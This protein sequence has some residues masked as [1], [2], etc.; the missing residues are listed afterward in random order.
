MKGEPRRLWLCCISRSNPPRGCV[1]WTWQLEG[2]GGQLVLFFRGC[3]FACL[4]G[5][6]RERSEP[7]LPICLPSQA[8]LG[9]LL[10]TWR[11]GRLYSG[12]SPQG[13][14]KEPFVIQHL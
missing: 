5:E 9:D 12:R 4:C 10:P 3:A 11:G 2:T 8:V 7:G 6:E 1:Q 13:R 14:L